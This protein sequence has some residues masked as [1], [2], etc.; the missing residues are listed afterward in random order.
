MYVY[1]VN[2]EKEIRARHELPE[3]KSP[4]RTPEEEAKIRR[5]LELQQEAYWRGIMEDMMEEE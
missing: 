4:V 3:R 1:Y 2:Y 5:E